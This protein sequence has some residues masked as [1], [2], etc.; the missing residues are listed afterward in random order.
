M[1]AQSTFVGFIIALLI[2]AFVLVPTFLLIFDYSKPTAKALD[3][4]RIGK[5]QV[6]GGP[7]FIYFKSTPFNPC[8][9][10]PNPISYTKL[11]GVYFEDKGQLLN[12]TSL[13]QAVRSTS[14]GVA[15]VGNLT[16]P[17]PLVYN[18]TLPKRAWNTTLVLQL[19]YYNVTV[20]ATVYPNETAFAS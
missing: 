7:V 15:V 2:I 16:K 10:V 5:D 20:F 3:L 1:R 13:V 19:I 14:N 9:L 4:A 11:T 8:L 17:Y 12:I 6:N 18:F